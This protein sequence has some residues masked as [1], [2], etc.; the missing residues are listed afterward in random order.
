MSA[1]RS[2][3]A[4]NGFEAGRRSAAYATYASSPPLRR[5]EENH[6]VFGVAN[7]KFKVDSEIYAE[8][9]EATSFYRVETGVVRTCKFLSDG[10]RQIDAFYG[11]GELFGL[12]AGSQHGLSAEAVCAC[13]L[14]PYRRRG[15]ES[16]A[17]DTNSM[18]LNMF[19]Y[20]MDCLERV[21][22]H[23]LLLG[24]GSAAQKLA[25]FL[26]EMLGHE[27]AG[28]IVDLAMT[29]QDVADYLGLTIETISRTLSQFEREGIIAFVTARRIILK[30]R[31]ALSAMLTS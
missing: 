4:D 31:A 28:G 3:L 10:R 11:A 1:S 15:L 24:R 18:A 26:V 7:L 23:A 6:V 20:A 30:N 21:R 14:T 29:R 16:L 17:S 25:N 19:S 22:A 13:T 12:E 2:M 5:L 8:G 9:D 27:N